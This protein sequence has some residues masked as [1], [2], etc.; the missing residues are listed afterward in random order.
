MHS[1]IIMNK[2]IIMAE[3]RILFWAKI[4]ADLRLKRS[5]IGYD[6]GPIQSRTGADHVRWSGPTSGPFR[7]RFGYILTSESGTSQDLNRT[8]IGRKIGC[9]TSGPFLGRYRVRF[10][11]D[12]GSVSGPI[13]GPI[14]GRYRVHFWADIGSDSGPISGPILGRHRVRFWPDSDNIRTS[15]DGTSKDLSR[16]RF[17][18]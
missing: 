12:I 4:G 1:F 10:W 6:S 7:A 17:G 5:R 14:L 9:Q 3:N 13:S 18:R 11:A 16:T 15:E 8:R 2:H